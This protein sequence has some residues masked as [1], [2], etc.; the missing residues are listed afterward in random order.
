MHRITI[1]PTSVQWRGLRDSVN[2]A[3]EILDLEAL[4]WAPDGCLPLMERVISGPLD[5][6]SRAASLS[7]L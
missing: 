1:E 5:G 6:I 3:G 7:R 2:Y 4:K